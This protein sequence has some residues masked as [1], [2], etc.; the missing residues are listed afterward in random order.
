MAY[1]PGQYGQYSQPTAAPAASGYNNPQQV[2]ANYTQ[3]G[4]FNSSASGT[5]TS[6]TNTSTVASSFGYQQTSVASTTP[7]QTTAQT[8]PSQSYYGYTNVSSTTVNQP[9]FHNFANLWY[10]Q[11][12]ANNAAAAAQTTAQQ[13][14]S[15]QTRQ[16]Q[17]SVQQ[18]ASLHAQYM[19]YQQ[20]FVQQQQQQYQQ[21][22][23]QLAN[24]VATTAASQ[25]A[26]KS[27]IGAKSSPQSN[28]GINQTT[29]AA[30]WGNAATPRTQHESFPTIPLPNQ[31]QTDPVSRTTGWGATFTPQ[32]HPPS[33]PPQPQGKDWTHVTTGYQQQNLSRG[34]YG[35]SGGDLS[36]SQQQAQMNMQRQNQAFTQQGK[37]PSYPNQSPQ[38]G[39]QQQQ[40]PNLD[41]RAY[42]SR[43]PDPANFPPDARA[44][45]GQHANNWG[46]NWNK[47]QGWGDWNGAQNRPRVNED[48]PNIPPFPEAWQMGNQPPGQN[49]NWDERNRANWNQA[50]WQQQTGFEQNGAR[51]NQGN[52]FARGDNQQRFPN[53]GRYSPNSRQSRGEK[54]DR[55]LWS[56]ADNKK[57]FGNKVIKPQDSPKENVSDKI[58]QATE[59]KSYLYSWLS[60]RHMHPVYDLHSTGERPDQTFRCELRVQGYKF[61]GVGESTNKKES[62]NDAAWSFADFLVKQGELTPSE[63]PAKTQMDDDIS[64]NFGV[65][66]DDESETRVEIQPKKGE[67]ASG[68]QYVRKNHNHNQMNMKGPKQ[69]IPPLM[70]L[71]TAPPGHPHMPPFMDRGCAPHEMWGMPLHPP[72]HPPPWMMGPPP[73]MPGPW[74]GMMGGPRHGWHPKNDYWRLEEQWMEEI[75]HSQEYQ[76]PEDIFINQMI[77]RHKEATMGVGGGMRPRPNLAM[78]M[79]GRGGGEWQP[80][81]K[82]RNQLTMDDRHIMAKHAAIYPHEEELKSVH[83]LV[84][85]A[86][87]AL[88]ALSDQ[89]VDEDHPL[90]KSEEEI[91]EENL[92][93]EDSTE[94][95]EDGNEEKSTSGDEDKQEKKA[96]IQILKRPKKQ[97]KKLIDTR[98]RILCAVNRVGTLAKGL[99]IHNDPNVSLVLLCGNVPT[100][101]LL[102]RVLK[103]LPEKMKEVNKTLEFELEE[104]EAG[105]T[106]FAK[107]AVKV[108]VLVTLTSTSLNKPKP[109]VQEEKEAE[110]EKVTGPEGG[111]GEDEGH[112]EDAEKEEEKQEGDQSEEEKKEETEDAENNPTEQK[113]ET[114]PKEQEESNEQKY[115]CV[116]S[117]TKIDEIE[118]ESNNEE[119]EGMLPKHLLLDALAQLRHA[120]W[121]QARASQLDCCV[122]MI[123]ILRD[124]KL[125]EEVW[126]PLSN[127]AIENLVYISLSSSNEQMGH[128]DA[129]RRVFE[130]LAGGVLLPD[131][132]GVQDPCEKDK[133][134]VLDC[135][136]DQEL[137]E[138]TRYAQYV[139]LKIAFRQ[140]H[141]VLGMERLSLNAPRPNNHYPTSHNVNSIQSKD[142][143]GSDLPNKQHSESDKITTENVTETSP[144]KEDNE[145]EQKL[146]DLS[147]TDPENKHTEAVDL[148]ENDRVTEQITDCPEETDKNSDTDTTDKSQNLDQSSCMEKN[149]EL[150]EAPSEP[151]PNPDQIQQQTSNTED[152]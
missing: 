55:E 79:D 74:R 147:I 6:S 92:D 152:N 84:T 126:N 70:S 91:E 119:I 11:T 17:M 71:V 140:I 142:E 10:S 146:A 52:R 22:Q 117:E 59:I 23:Q 25:Q 69:N 136:S 128:G 1:Y 81:Y 87:Q 99:L 58:V 28:I 137:E 104:N 114:P 83:E 120:K 47:D 93:K 12:T 108:K 29:V 40:G 97:P 129:F 50:N 62:L 135:C 61:V 14:Q 94:K 65:V 5:S 100:Q 109:K 103:H 51:Q 26:Y 37:T 3:Y 105:F 143:N 57:K 122:V 63:L 118:V 131:R 43:P 27:P 134:D 88:K 77:M 107:L 112:K 66:K 106:I 111:V 145:N 30:S 133:V 95:T 110:E 73:P 7:S 89:F 127:W 130:V 78:P 80:Q 60:M 150:K 76:N 139:L 18:V 121:F 53:N 36:W 96:K 19:G 48:G 75:H 56:P 21:Q 85:I 67:V 9:T 34:N 116:D 68:N 13:Q 123:R 98:P 72:P 31:P 20:A 32:Q 42:N 90:P 151:E 141:Q 144:V 44:A 46:E 2:T 38:Y 41:T 132:P 101:K 15:T 16:A 125:R 86:E 54:T 35:V 102:Q 148:Q 82:N 138:M 39:G 124:L 33:Q 24:T 64:D 49:G 115:T 8:F 113:E 4:N 149:S 45:W